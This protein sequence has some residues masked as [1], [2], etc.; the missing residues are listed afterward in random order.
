MDL[1]TII[2]ENPDIN[3]TVKASDLLEFGKQ[4]ATQS[5]NKILENKKEKLFTRKE[6]IEIFK[7]AEASLWRW[8]QLGIIKST[9]V[10]GRKY[11]SESE[12]QRI[13]SQK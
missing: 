10:G 2:L 6:T 12:I 7:I 5:T 1:S 13:L 4:I 9:K 3:I 11:Y 8:D